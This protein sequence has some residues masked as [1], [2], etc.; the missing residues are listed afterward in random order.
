M[1]QLIPLT[2]EQ[3]E[4]ILNSHIKENWAFGL[5]MDQNGNWFIDP[6]QIEESEDQSIKHLLEIQLQECVHAPTV[7]STT[8]SL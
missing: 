1:A 2:L 3:K 8:G 4:L 5:D 6:F 7:Q